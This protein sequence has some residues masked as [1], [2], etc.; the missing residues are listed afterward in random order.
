MIAVIRGEVFSIQADSVVLMAGGVG[1]E[2]FCTSGTLSHLADSKTKTVTLL[3]YTHVTEDLLQLFGF[4][5][6]EE[7]QLFL[8]LLK[9]NGIGAK[10]AI[11][12]LSGTTLK[13]LG[14]MVEKGDVKSLSKLPKVG[15]KTAEQMILT[16]KGKLVLSDSVERKTLKSKAKTEIGSALINLG[17]RSQD[18]EKVITGLPEEIQ[19]EEGIRQ[20][21]AA[22]T[23][24]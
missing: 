15:K 24:L 12:I 7:K 21:L 13:D 20:G 22:L 18:V 16:L 4:F 8:S 6:D 1:Y 19:I 11:Q 17:F 10:T 5:T 14:E 9:V 23:S 3:A 2:L